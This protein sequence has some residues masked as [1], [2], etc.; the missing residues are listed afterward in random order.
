MLSGM[1]RKLNNEKLGKLLI[2]EWSVDYRRVTPGPNYSESLG[3]DNVEVVF[4][5][6]AHVSGEAQCLKMARNLVDVLICATGFDTIFKPRFSLVRPT[7]Q[8]LSE[9]WK[10]EPQSY[11]GVAVPNYLTTS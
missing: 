9:V 10:D 3:R 8:E 11:L 6:I 1:K 4:G 5:E 7:G 2:L